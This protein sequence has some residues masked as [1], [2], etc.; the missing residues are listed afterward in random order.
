MR[1]EQMTVPRDIHL[2][3]LMDYQACF[4][5]KKPSANSGRDAFF[6]NGKSFYTKLIA[7]KNILLYGILTTLQ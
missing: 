6:R 1:I 2:A 3:T 5:S 4:Q 7:I